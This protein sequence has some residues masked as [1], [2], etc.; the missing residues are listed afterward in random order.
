M[1]A[2]KRSHHRPKVVV[3]D[4]SDSKA[5]SDLRWRNGQAFF[6]FARD[7]YSD[8]VAMDKETFNEWAD[9]GSLGGWYNE[10]L[11]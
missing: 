11:R 5:I 4:T 7:G 6:T 2:Q 8:S 10:N 3:A 9:S 1:P